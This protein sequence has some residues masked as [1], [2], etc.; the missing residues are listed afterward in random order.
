MAI[1]R[2]ILH[3]FQLPATPLP[4]SSLC[5]ACCEAKSH[6]LPFHRSSTTSTRPLQLLFMDVWGPAPVVSREGFRFYLSIVDA[7][8]RYTWFFPLQCKSDVYN[9]FVNFQKTVERFFM[10]KISSVQTDWG[11]EFR[12]LHTFL[13]SQG[14]TH[15]RSCTH[16]HQQNGS[17]ERKHRHIVE[18]GLALMAHAG[19]PQQ[20][21]IDAFRTAVF[22]I[23]R[24]QSLVTQKMSPFFFC[25]INTTTIPFFVCL[26]RSLSSPSSLS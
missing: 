14:I 7:F 11:G 6:S 22:L 19:M 4:V 21:W 13:I 12:S 10:L 2:H 3:R 23:N 20:F 25:S 24:L 26:D 1:V 16:I 5:S 8:S 17:V 18:S 15:R 9:Q